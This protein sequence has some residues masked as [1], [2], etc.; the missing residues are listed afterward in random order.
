MKITYFS[1]GEFARLC[2]TTKET[3]RH[4]HNIGLLVPAIPFTMTSGIS[5]GSIINDSCKKYCPTFLG[6]TP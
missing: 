5:A 6:L 2:G 3:L 4:Y 1:S